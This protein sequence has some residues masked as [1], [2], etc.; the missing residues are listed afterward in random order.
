MD[1]INR[2][3]RHITHLFNA[4]TPLHHRKPGIVGAALS[5]NVTC[6]IIVDNIHIHPDLYSFVYKNKGKDNMVL[7][8]DSMRAGCMKEGIY[9]LGG[10]T[11][12]VKDSAAR[13][14]DGTIAGSILSLEKAFQNMI[15]HTHLSILD[16]SRLL[17]LNPARVIGIDRQKGSIEIDKDADLI[18]LDKNYKVTR[19]IVNG[20]TVY[21]K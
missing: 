11:V 13:L 6:E 18:F 19:T 15:K 21:T 3:A 17:S 4:M 10:Q 20:K 2:G 8:T 5:T 1:A 7:I 9:E 12:I 16:L 14:E